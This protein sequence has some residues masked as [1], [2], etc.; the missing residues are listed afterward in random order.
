M[1]EGPAAP[2][3]EAH[4]VSCPSGDAKGD[5]LCRGRGPRGFPD[6]AAAKARATF[7]FCSPLTTCRKLSKLFTLFVTRFSHVWNGNDK[8]THLLSGAVG[9]HGD[10]VHAG[11]LTQAHPSEASW[12]LVACS[13]VSPYSCTSFVA[14]NRKV[15]PNDS[16]GPAAEHS[17]VPAQ[18]LL[19][20][21]GCRAAVPLPQRHWE[22][23]EG[24]SLPKWK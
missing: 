21:G 15:S 24:Q 4:G 22:T 13:F 12:G 9:E 19:P 11:L 8:S 18:D 17:P 2:K 3:A 20:L 7:R 5:Y 23:M 1:G 16:M 6:S 10:F 14:L